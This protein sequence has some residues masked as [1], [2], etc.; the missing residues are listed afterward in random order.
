MRV[1]TAENVFKVKRSWADQCSWPKLMGDRALSESR[2][3][4]LAPRT[5]FLLT[6]VVHPAWTLLR[7]VSNHI[8]FLLLMIY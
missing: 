8:C 5:H 1:Q 3:L 6:S 7:S 2:S 4:V